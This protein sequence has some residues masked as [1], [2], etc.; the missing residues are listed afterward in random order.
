M[1][2]L[3]GIDFTST[4]TLEYLF[5]SV[6]AYNDGLSNFVKEAFKYLQNYDV[7]ETFFNDMK[8]SKLR[9]Y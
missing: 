7:D 4:T 8:A 2:D 5:F 3:A 9:A 1:A 6:F